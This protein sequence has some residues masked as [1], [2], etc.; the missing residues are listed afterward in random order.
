MPN[1]ASGKIRIVPRTAAQAIHLP[2]A[3]RFCF[4]TRAKPMYDDD[5]DDQELR[6][7]IPIED[8]F[9]FSMGEFELGPNETSDTMRQLV[10]VLIIDA[11]E[12]AERWRLA[13]QA[14]I[15]LAARWP[16][17]PGFRRDRSE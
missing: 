5:E 4:K 14:R 6:L 1:E 10:G 12:Y 17:C 16:D 3:L 7:T 15:F 13:A 11:L 2:N 8:A 9:S